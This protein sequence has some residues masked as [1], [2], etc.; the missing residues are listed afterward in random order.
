M[1]FAPTSPNGSPDTQATAVYRRLRSDILEGR[2]APGLRLKVQEL[3][4][5]YGAGPAPLR[6]ALAQ[7][8]AEGLARRIEQRGFR[9]ADAD[10]AGFAGL[11]R[12][13]C[14]AEALALRESI[15]RGDAAWEDALAAAERR[16]AR[17]PRSTDP[18]RFVSNP[19]WESAHR[20]FHH[21]L[22]AACEAPPLLAFCDRLREE[23]DRYRAL[24]NAVAYPGRD[25]AAEHA[26]IAEAA[27]D[28]DADRAAALLS[29]HLAATGEFVRVALEKR[30]ASQRGGR[31]AEAAPQP[32]A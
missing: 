5:H 21:A 30:H 10:P 17:L 20:A 4:G 7:L 22:I 23:A 2:L 27:L 32:R 15:A 11:I 13:R 1:S 24:A 31:R 28:R 6:E 18:A 14:L 3:A 25:V 8:A 12:S 29:E 9:V 16:L 19:A 26:A